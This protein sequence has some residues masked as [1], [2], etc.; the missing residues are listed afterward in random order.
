MRPLSSGVVVVVAEQVQETV[1]RQD[2]QLG[3]VGMAGLGRLAPGDAG[4]NDDD[5]PR[6]VRSGSLGAGNDS[7]SVARSLRR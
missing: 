1:K 3:G 7:T 4:G 6:S 5:R 2:P